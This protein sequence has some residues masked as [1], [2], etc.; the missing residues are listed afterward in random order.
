MVNC[1][2]LISKWVGDTGKNIEGVFSEAKSVDAVLVFDE[3]EGLFG[4]RTEQSS[5]TD[6][7]ANIDVGLML[8]EIE[9]FKGIVILVSNL[10]DKID[11]AFFR[12]YTLISIA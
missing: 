6:R 12:R 1:A 4:T 11:P 7:Y 2:E 8:Y 3:A 9:R 5:S 10:P